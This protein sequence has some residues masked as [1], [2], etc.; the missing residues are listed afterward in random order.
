MGYKIQKTLYKLKFQDNKYDGLEVTVKSV[1]LGTL[2]DIQESGALDGKAGLVKTCELLANNITEWN[3]EDEDGNPIG[4]ALS[5]LLD[6]ESDFIIDVVGAWTNAMVSVSA[7]L[8]NGSKNGGNTAELNLPMETL[9]TN[10][11]N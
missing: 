9:S 8:P 10:L 3:V 5:D 4:H 11:T 2:I 7:P 6:M 1:P